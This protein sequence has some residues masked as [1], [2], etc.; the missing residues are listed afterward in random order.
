MSVV[1]K[2]FEIGKYRTIILDE[3]SRAV[4]SK[5]LI[6][7]VERAIVPT[8]PYK[9]NVFSVINDGVSLLGKEVEFI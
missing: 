6:D 8:T 4:Y 3:G 1:T 7:G 2:E 5:L 9:D